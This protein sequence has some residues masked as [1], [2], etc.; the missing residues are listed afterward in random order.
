MSTPRHDPP[1]VVIGG[2]LAGITA[3]LR[4]ADRGRA[5]TLIEAKP[6]LGGLTASFQ[7]DGLAVDTGQH[8]FMRCCTAYRALLDRLGVTHLTTLQPRLDIAVVRAATGRRG[9]IR[10]DPLPVA[11]GLPL[12]LGRSLASYS[13]LSPKARVAASRAALALRSVDRDDPV[14]DDRSFG[15]WL[16][17]HGQAADAI[18]ALWDLVGVATLN[19]HADQASLAL[20]AT[21]FQLGLLT[22]PG[23]AD[24]G[25]SRVA[26]QQ[27]H[28]D[29]ATRVLRVAGV[30]VRLKT[31]VESLA[32][33]SDGWL[34]TGPTGSIDAAQVVVAT[35]PAAGERLLPADSLDLAAGWAARLGEAPIVNVHAVFDRPVLDDPFL[36]C[37]GSPL[38]WLF[39]RTE[40]GGLTDGQYVAASLSAAD[41]VADRPVAEL[42]ELMLPEF[43][44]V[45]PRSRD[46]VLHDFFVTREPHATF[47]Q[48]P[49]SGR[50]RPT[51]ATRHHGLV[52][53][54]AHTA[55]GWPATMESAVR[56]GDAAAQQLLAEPAGHTQDGVAA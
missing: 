24:L 37:V 38:Q 56:S 8:V 1:A 34:V 47:R 3:A 17:D 11:A 2:G 21:V 5:V 42:R 12:H 51:T 30:D 53:A 46:A 6:R 22:D 32:A 9:R 50:S 36:A 43:H 4:L 26:L 39:D 13:L 48:A 44:R 35:E 54:G 25:W 7:R 40:A 49:G 16:S 14:T 28:G 10:R 41:D 29:A 15:D 33:T 18:A 55:T 27:L 52:L 31:R 23:A 20:A 19:A 45:L